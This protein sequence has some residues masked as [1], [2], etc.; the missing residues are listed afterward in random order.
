MSI[1]KSCRD[2][3]GLV[4]CH[5]CSEIYCTNCFPIVEEFV[6]DTCEHEVGGLVKVGD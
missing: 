2:Y 4:R 5:R 6:E 3:K 1:C